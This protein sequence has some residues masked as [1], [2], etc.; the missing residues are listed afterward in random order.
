MTWVLLS[1][2]G[3]F[4]QAFGWALKKKVLDNTNVNNTLG[5]VSFA[6]AGIVLWVWYRLSGTYVVDLSEKFWIASL[7]IIVLN[8][9][10]AW[11]AY[12]A[13]DK[14]ALSM[15]M[16]FVSLTALAIVPIE[17]LLRGVAPSLFQIIGIAVVVIGGIVLTVKGSLSKEV[18]TVAGYFAV[19][20]VCYSIS[21]PLM[22]VAIEESRSGIFSA[23]VFHL[24]IAIGFVPLMVMAGEVPAIRSLQNSGRWLY[25][26]GIMVL[27]GLIVALLENGPISLALEDANASEV[28][29]LKRTMPFFALILGIMMFGEQVTRRHAFGT[30]LLVLG[31]FLIVWFR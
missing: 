27:T 6:V 2:L 4:G 25:L 13:I 10:A 23:A 29:A 8:V 24:G 1:L 11:S 14:A 15:L 7:G 9:C 18:F 3:A 28:F 12:K 17:F 31:S 16:P 21:S 20:L 22:A 30:A 26:L 5:V 19:T